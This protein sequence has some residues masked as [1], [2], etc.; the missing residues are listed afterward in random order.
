MGNFSKFS[1]L[2]FFLAGAVRAFFVCVL[3]FAYGQ[4]QLIPT[5]SVTIVQ[6][7]VISVSE[8]NETVKTYKVI[9]AYSGQQYAVELPNDPGPSI[10]IQV[11]SLPTSISMPQ[12]N[13][14]DASQASANSTVSLVPAFS[15]PYVYYS[16]MLYKPMPVFLGAGYLRGGGYR[17]GRG[18]RH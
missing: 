11:P 15:Y 10:Q 9:Y 6:L 16:G 13:A 18:R 7:P 1:E 3:S 12:L 17:M 14:S 5:E 8:F 4:Q 2:R